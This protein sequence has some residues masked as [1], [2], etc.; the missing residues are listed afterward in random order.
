MIT[1]RVFLFFLSLVNV[2]L[3]FS[4]PR[5]E[6]E[7]TEL[8]IR[9]FSE[10]TTTRGG[11]GDLQLNLVPQKEIDDLFE[12]SGKK[13]VKVRIKQSPEFYIF[14]ETSSQK[15]VI[16]SADKRQH[17]I[18]GIS[19]KGLFDS[20][21]IPCGLLTFLIQYADEYAYLQEK[22]V[23]DKMMYSPQ[24]ETRSYSNT[25]ILIKTTW[26][27]TYPY[28]LQC[29]VIGYSRCVTGCVATA[30][31]QIMNYHQ[32]PERGTGVVRNSTS[33]ESLDLAAQTF[34]WDGLKNFTYSYS[35]R[36]ANAVA[37]LMK[38]CGYAVKTDYGTTLSTAYFENVPYAFTHNF[39]YDESCKLISRGGYS[40]E[41]WE[42]LIQNELLNKRPICYYGNN[43][44]QEN[45]H[46][47]ILDGYESSN[48]VYH[49]NWGWGGYLD[50]FFK[51]TSLRPGNDDFSYSNNMIINI[52]TKP[53]ENFYLS[54]FDV[55]SG[56]YKELAIQ[57]ESKEP[58]KYIGFQFDIHMPKG[59][60][61]EQNG[62]KYN[63]KF[64]E[65]RGEGVS[66]SFENKKDGSIRVFGTS[67]TRQGFKGI[68]GD[69]IYL[70]VSAAN[71]FIGN[72]QIEIKNIIFNSKDNQKVGFPDIITN[73]IGNS[74]D[75]Y[76]FSARGVYYKIRK[77]MTLEVVGDCNNQ[78]NEFHSKGNID[79]P[80][81]VSYKGNTYKVTNI[82]ERAFEGSKGLKSIKIPDSVTDIG[83]NAFT[84]CTNLTNVTISNSI[85]SIADSLFGQ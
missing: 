81:T 35:E 14:N 31:A 82:K 40:Q 2:L 51:L 73:I 74:D 15:F 71:N 7:A 55:P 27:Q 32:H 85:T 37:Y 66:L 16:V 39:L 64:N 45:G 61:I 21:K 76:D 50:G 58:D 67:Q 70:S 19:D 57:F 78:W 10:Q 24:V 65:E 12:H 84:W 80:A 8:A 75:F 18:L 69:F 59:L 54:D 17:E 22:E 23:D 25:D 20:K 49:F 34:D 6:D 48:D 3:I 26:N 60:T 77:G 79:I 47:F 1:K 63:I 83:N 56:M 62:N 9:F 46:A 29:P 53:S 33:K 28:N 41:E 42:R 36:G 43:S 4:Q 38:A 44:F 11:T 52:S 30:M 68:A 72:Y 5:S 13:R